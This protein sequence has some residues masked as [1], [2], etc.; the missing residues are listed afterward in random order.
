MVNHPALPP[1][2]SGLGTNQVFGRDT[3]ETERGRGYVAV[4]ASAKWMSTSF[5]GKASTATANSPVQKAESDA[6][7]EGA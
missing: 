6:I 4:A 7:M 2:Q 1:W 5:S 3:E